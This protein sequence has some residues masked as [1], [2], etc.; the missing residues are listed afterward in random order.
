M[1]CESWICPFAVDF[2]AVRL[3]L[4]VRT[5]RGLWA[6]VNCLLVSALHLFCL[7]WRKK[8]G[9]LEALKERVSSV[10]WGFRSPSLW[11]WRVLTG[12]RAEDVSCRGKNMILCVLMVLIWNLSIIK[13]RLHCDHSQTARL[14]HYCCYLDAPEWLRVTLQ[15]L[16]FAKYH[17]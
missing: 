10:S 2:A 9:K 11:L 17:M 1:L 12:L 14:R 15:H 7:S 8:E 4:S 3:K 6:P 13:W 16:R 5:A